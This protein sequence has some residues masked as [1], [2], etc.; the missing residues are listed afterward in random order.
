MNKYFRSAI[1]FESH[2]PDDARGV[3]AKY[4]HTRPDICLGHICRTLQRK[5]RG[6]TYGTENPPLL[7]G[8]SCSLICAGGYGVETVE[9]NSKLHSALEIIHVGDGKPLLQAI[10]SI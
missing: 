9:V 6:R 4:S 7:T 2:S 8:V 3:S 5:Q 10:L 1:L